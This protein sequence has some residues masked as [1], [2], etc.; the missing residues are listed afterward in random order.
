MLLDPPTTVK[1]WT[2]RWNIPTK[3]HYHGD[4][5]DELSG[6]FRLIWL[7]QQ[8]LGAVIGIIGEWCPTKPFCDIVANS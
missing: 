3:R 2:K 7:L 6:G 4:V 8:D 5:I 1:Y